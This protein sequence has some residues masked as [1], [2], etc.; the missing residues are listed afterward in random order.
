VRTGK[1]LRLDPEEAK[2]I[3]EMVK[4]LQLKHVVITC[5]AR[6]DLDDRGGG[7]FIKCIREVRAQCSDTKVEILTTDFSLKYNVI[8]EV[9]AAEPDVFNHNIETVR[10]LTPHIRHTASY[11]N[12]LRFLAYLK[13]KNPEQV[14]KSGLMLGLGETEDEVIEALVDL[15]DVGCETVTIGQ[16]LR[17]SMKNLPVKAFI[18]P[19]KFDEYKQTAY[20]MGF[21]SVASGPFVRS[22]YRAEKMRSEL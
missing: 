9:L 14:T 15:R 16:Y 4:Q 2:H 10:R 18:E 12:S 19:N 6:D 8:D 13:E 21:R 17:P 11:E 20:E 7:Q 1:P 3:S 22:S 5:V